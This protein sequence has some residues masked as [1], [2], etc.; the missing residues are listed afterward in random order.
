MLGITNN[1][2]P[3]AVQSQLFKGDYQTTLTPLP[4]NIYF[5]CNQVD[6]IS[7]EIN[8]QPSK[9]LYTWDVS[10][11]QGDLTKKTKLYPN[12]FIYNYT[13]RYKIAKTGQ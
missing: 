5:Y 12:H 7:N 8:G 2:K 4:K 11:S 13:H 6:E 3:S 10:E 1:I 9:L